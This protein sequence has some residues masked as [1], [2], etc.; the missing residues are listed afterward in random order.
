M[1]PRSRRPSPPIR[2]TSIRVILLRARNQKVHTAPN[3]TL[4]LPIYLQSSDM[5]S[6]SKELTLPRAVRGK[7]R[8]ILLGCHPM[9]LASDVVKS[10]EIT[11]SLYS[12]YPAE[13]H[14]AEET[15]SLLRLPSAMVSPWAT[16]NVKL[17]ETQSSAM[18][19]GCL[20]VW[21]SGSGMSLIEAYA[22]EPTNEDDAVL[23]RSKGRSSTSEGL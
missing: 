5:S 2:A 22:K 15:N 14:T 3:V 20:R 23:C 7:E 19:V 13:R 10:S 16:E 1:D 6:A 17:M 12:V 9:E 8:T 4:P 11:V 21:L 18:G